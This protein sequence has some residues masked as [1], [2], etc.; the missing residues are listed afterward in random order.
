MRN[1]ARRVVEQLPLS[2]TLF[3]LGGK[4]RTESYHLDLRGRRA[5][6]CVGDSSLDAVVPC[7]ETHVGYLTNPLANQLMNFLVSPY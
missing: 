5:D 2:K 7:S 4:G 6:K 1:D 3:R